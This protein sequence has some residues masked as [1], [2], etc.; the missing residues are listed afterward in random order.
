MAR[1]LALLALALGG[2]VHAGRERA[3]PNGELAALRVERAAPHH[4]ELLAAFRIEGLRP[5]WSPGEAR[6]EV[7]LEDQ[8]FAAAVAV[9]RRAGLRLE[10][11]LVLA[12]AELPRDAAQ[13]ARA[14]HPVRVRL[15]GTLQV[16]AEGEA[17]PVP[18]DV[19]QTLPLQSLGPTP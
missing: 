5:T 7:A 4:L 13:V 1:R 16:T 2:C 17:L 15:R 10:V 6:L 9:E 19:E 3:H 12:Y 11:P 8:P 14:G 18:V